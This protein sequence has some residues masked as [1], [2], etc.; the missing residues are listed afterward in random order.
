MEDAQLHE[1]LDA[2]GQRFTPSIPDEV[3]SYFLETAG[4]ST[5]DPR[6]IRMVGLVAQKFVLD[7]GHDA[8]LYQQHRL[9]AHHHPHHKATLTMEDLSASLKELIHADLDQV[10]GKSPRCDGRKVDKHNSQHL[11]LQQVEGFSI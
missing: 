7:V 6:I 5:D 4:F 8:K 1:F 9:N 2:V 3:V 11:E 10:L